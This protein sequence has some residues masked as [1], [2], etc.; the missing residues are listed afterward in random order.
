MAVRVLMQGST[1]ATKSR[2]LVKAAG[3]LIIWRRIYDN[4]GGVLNTARLDPGG[5]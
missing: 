2:A 5:R 3:G 4:A 1:H